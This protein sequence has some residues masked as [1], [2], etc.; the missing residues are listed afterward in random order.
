MILTA[1]IL[2]TLL[3]FL[4]GAI[5]IRWVMRYG[6]RKQ[7]FDQPDGERK[8]HQVPVPRLGGLTLFP[9]LSI[10]MAISAVLLIPIWKAS[11]ISPW[12]ELQLFLGLFFSLGVLYTLGVKEDTHGVRSLYKFVF[13]TIAAL[14]FMAFGIHLSHTGGMFWLDV[15]LPLWLWWIITYIAFM[16]ALNAMNLIDGVD[17]LSCDISILSLSVLGYLEY[18]ERHIAFTLLAI[19]AVSA[20]LA[21]RWYNIHGDKKTSQRIFMGDT[22]CWTLGIIMLFLIIHLNTLTPRSPHQH[23]ALIGY[24][25]LIVPLLDLPRVGM[26]RM[27]RGIQPFHPDNNHI[28]HKLL[29]LGLKPWGVRSAILGFTV[30]MIAFNWWMCTRM[31]IGLL[32]LV[33]AA[34]YLLLVDI[35]DILRKRYHKKHHKQ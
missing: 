4:F 9:L 7:L 15:E 28:H 27:V 5:L 16:H 21:F 2:D 35:I 30:L 6:Y 3:V 26:Y 19:A 24:T 18:Q 29:D 25:T 1:F 10:T 32:M 33:N 22:G 11:W 13:Y 31:D 23:Y 17:G 8:I 20:L 12:S 14:V 34:Q